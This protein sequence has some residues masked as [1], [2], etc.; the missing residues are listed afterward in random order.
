[1]PAAT[2][3]LEAGAA[4]VT[5]WVCCCAWQA[6]AEGQT[7]TEWRGALADKAERFRRQ[8]DTWRGSA[9]KL[10]EAGC[11]PK[12]RSL[13]LRRHYAS[14]GVGRPWTTWRL[15]ARRLA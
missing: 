4:H 8:W 11:W 9:D 5:A 3:A 12:R 14:S 13:S 1:M 10:R 7:Q 6:A 2:R 15:R